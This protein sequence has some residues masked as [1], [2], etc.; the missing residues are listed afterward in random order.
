MHPGDPS[1]YPS[2]VWHMSPWTLL[3]IH[4]IIADEGYGRGDE[5]CVKIS[6]KYKKPLYVNYTIK[7]HYDWA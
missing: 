6:H 4:K 2:E 5:A 3:D 7:V 1:T